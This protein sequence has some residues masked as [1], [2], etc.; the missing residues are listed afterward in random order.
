MRLPK[1]DARS[2]SDP[3]LAKLLGKMLAAWCQQRDQLNEEG[4]SR[5]LFS[6]QLTIFQKSNTLLVPMRAEKSRL[7]KT[8]PPRQ[9]HKLRPKIRGRC[10]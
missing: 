1:E 6:I 8:Y 5:A 3:V 4:L 10:S 2:R 9:A 7:M